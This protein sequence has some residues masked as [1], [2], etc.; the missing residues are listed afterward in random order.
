MPDGFGTD[1]SSG[2]PLLSLIANHSKGEL[3]MKFMGL[4]MLAVP[5][6][7]A[8]TVSF[9]SAQEGAKQQAR[10]TTQD[11]KDAAKKTGNAISDSWITLKIHSQFVPEDAL[12]DSDIDVDTKSGIVT[13]NGT[14]AS[15][16]GRA[17]AVAIAKATDGV[18]A[19][20]DKLKVGPAAD[21]TASAKA[22][23]EKAGEKTRE[24]A[25]TSGKAVTDGW[26]KSKIASQYVTEDLLDKSDIDIDVSK[27][28][29][30]LTG[31][32]RTM[33]AKNKA[34][35]L[36][37]GTDGVKSVQNNLKVDPNVK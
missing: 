9:A 6:L 34:T 37:K 5:V 18:T 1:G 20:T 35:A 15:E 22:A 29:V 28:A 36:A 30:E 3:A 25:G 13:L 14:V 10:E 16:A 23:G 7:L 8:A 26:I 32:V 27:G 17:K 24:V 4:R 11:V 12:A 19:V 33:E 21:M 2:R 31:A